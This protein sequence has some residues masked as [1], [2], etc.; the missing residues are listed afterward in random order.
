MAN[1]SPHVCGMCNRKRKLQGFYSA[2]SG[3]GTV[4]GE[5]KIK[6]VG[7]AGES[8]TGNIL[9]PVILCGW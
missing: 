1:A 2:V 7:H 8:L 6:V 4:S 5:E 9:V 3:L